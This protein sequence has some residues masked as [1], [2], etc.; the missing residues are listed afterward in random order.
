MPQECWDRWGVVICEPSFLT[1]LV[2][3]SSHLF[4]LILILWNL[5]KNTIYLDNPCF[6]CPLCALSRALESAPSPAQG[7][8]AP[9]G[10]GKDRPPTP[11]L[12]TGS[13]QIS[14]WSPR[15]CLSACAKDTSSPPPVSPGS[16]RGHPSWQ[17]FAFKVLPEPQCTGLDRASAGSLAQWVVFL[18]MAS[19]L[20]GAEPARVCADFVMAW[21]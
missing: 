4:A 10:Q 14:R 18:L 7:P 19:A 8:A 20:P 9:D 13:L 21:H 11:S 3:W 5:H 15:P 16:L 6:W 12:R 17:D 1:M 2:F